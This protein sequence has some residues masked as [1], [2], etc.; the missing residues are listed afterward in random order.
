MF[1]GQVNPKCWAK[2]RQ[3]VQCGRYA[4]DGQQVCAYHGGKSLRGPAHPSFKDGS[5]SKYV[6]R[7][8]DKL[9]EALNDPALME[10][11]ADVALL[12]ARL[13]ELLESGESALLW[14]RAASAVGRLRDAFQSGNGVN[15][16]AA[17]RELEDLTTRGL[18]D[19]I[20]WQEIYQVIESLTKTKEREV[21]RM[22][23]MQQ[24]I[25]SE[26]LLAILG[27]IANAAKQ[28]IRDPYDLRT[29]QKTIAVYSNDGVFQS[30]K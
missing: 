10:Y 4:L 1:R 12:G 13:N 17:F 20:R 29:F 18:E 21:R 8:D 30:D 26:Q 19:S 16:N 7:L 2:N 23:A 22:V 11:R 24:M 15:I 25:S 28:S 5:R 14:S 27:H 6:P 3:G 9:N